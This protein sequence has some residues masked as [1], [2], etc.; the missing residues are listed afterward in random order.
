MIRMAR[1]TRM[2]RST[3]LAACALALPAALFA[4][5]A[6]ARGRTDTMP[7]AKAPGQLTP[8]ARPAF[9]AARAAGQT[10]LVFFHAPW[11]SVCRAQEPKVAARLAGPASHVVAFK[12]D[13]DTSTALRAEMKVQ[14]QST[15]ILFE[16]TTEVARLS[17]KSDDASIDAFFEHAGM[18][19]PGAAR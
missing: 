14:K 15:L 13:Y 19:M 11:C 7:G 16:G 9:D 1:M 17:Y 10:T 3:V 8:F 12:A 5:Q 6:P 2:M 18:A 4:D